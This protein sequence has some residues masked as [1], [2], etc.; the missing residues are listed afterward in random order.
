VA[1]DVLPDSVHRYLD[2]DAVVSIDVIL[3]S[4]LLVTAA[5]AGRR[6][7]AVRALDDARGL[8]AERQRRLLCGEGVGSLPGWGKSAEEL[9]RRGRRPDLELVLGA[10]DDLAVVCTARGGVVVVAP[11]GD[12]RTRSAGSA[13]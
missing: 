2:F 5:A 7:L 9:R 12:G 13:A 6:A 11:E 8:I 4:T 1:V 3:D 10:V